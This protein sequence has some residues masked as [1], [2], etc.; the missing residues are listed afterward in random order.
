MWRE[1]EREVVFGHDNSCLGLDGA[2]SWVWVGRPIQACRSEGGSGCG[3]TTATPVKPG[4][5]E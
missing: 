3:P 2:H 4:G 5:G 1:K